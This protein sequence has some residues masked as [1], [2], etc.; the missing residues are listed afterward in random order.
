MPPSL[1]KSLVEAAILFD[2]DI[3]GFLLSSTVHYFLVL[4]S[5][6]NI[7]GRFWWLWSDWSQLHVLANTVHQITRVIYH[8]PVLFCPS[9]GLN[10]KGPGLWLLR[11]EKPLS[12]SHTFKKVLVWPTQNVSYYSHSLLLKTWF[13]FSW[14]KVTFYNVL[15]HLPLP[16]G[17]R[18]N[19]LFFELFWLFL[20]TGFA[21]CGCH[22]KDSAAPG[23]VLQG[24]QS[25]KATPGPACHWGDHNVAVVGG[26]R[27]E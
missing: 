26:R 7:F 2:H 19:S 27:K 21:N 24:R 22:P 13:V 3:G 18:L 9:Q 25:P 4:F 1:R 5:M 8:L 23:E 6:L 11:A 16:A 15:V 10:L 20:M 12:R 14:P 17:A